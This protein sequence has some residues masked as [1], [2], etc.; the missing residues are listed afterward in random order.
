MPSEIP[1]ALTP[2]EWA[3]KIVERG[4]YGATLH[5]DQLQVHGVATS[6]I[7]PDELRHPLAAFCLH[8]QKSGFTWDDVEE[9]YTGADAIE[10]EG[11]DGGPL[12]SLAN[13][14]AALL[15]DEEAPIA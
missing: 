7:V 15:W 4:S 8:E 12:R 5:H 9:A 13:R 14:L 1:P 2:R 6:L 11:G 10:R 3:A